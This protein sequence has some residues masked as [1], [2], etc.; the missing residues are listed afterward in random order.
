MTPFDE[1]SEERILHLSSSDFEKYKNLEQIALENGENLKLLIIHTAQDA[2]STFLRSERL[3]AE[4]YMEKK[5]IILPFPLDFPDASEDKI[6]LDDFVKENQE[7]FCF[8][9][10]DLNKLQFNELS[11]TKDWYDLALKKRLG[12]NNSLPSTDRDYLAEIF[13][14]G[15]SILDGFVRLSWQGYSVRREGQNSGGLRALNLLKKLEEETRNFMRLTADHKAPA[16]QVNRIYKF[17]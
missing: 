7:V 16:K 13:E 2:Y 8:K 11:S 5:K 17:I 1:N 14:F 3:F 15:L 4:R 6:N 10:L 9:E 12:N